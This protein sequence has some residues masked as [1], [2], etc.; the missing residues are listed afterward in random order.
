M[1]DALLVSPVTRALGLALVHFLWQGVAIGAIVAC[2]LR[3]AG[4][5]DPST[6]YAV[7]CAGLVAMLAAPA[8]T[9]LWLLAVATPAAA[10]GS[11]AGAVTWAVTIDV[12]A[13][14]S[15][16]DRVLPTIVLVW[17]AGVL[18]LALHLASGWLDVR[19]LRRSGTP[20]VRGWQD[21]ATALAGRLGIR[22]TVTVLESS[23]VGVPT[24][25]GW[26]RP[27][28]LLPTSV[29][30]G[31][32]PSQLDAIVT[33]EL[34]HVRRHDYLVN[35]FQSAIETLLFYHPAVWWV[36]N[37][38]RLEREHCCDDEAVR[39]CGDR[40]SYARALA[41]LEER[42][43]QA[44]KLGMAATG[45]QL[46]GR[47]RR[48][49]GVTP[50]GESRSPGLSALAVTMTLVPLL[51]VAG[52]AG[53]V[54]PAPEGSATR[55]ASPALAVE[56][57]GQPIRVGGAMTSPVKIRDV[58]PFY[59]ETAREA[60]VQGIVIVEAVISTS[61]EVEDARVLRGNPMLDSAALDA[62]RQWRYTPSL[63]NGQPVSVIMTVT[64]NFTLS[65]SG[66]NRTVPPASAGAVPSPPPPP[67]PGSEVTLQ[68]SSFPD[69]IVRAGGGIP[70]PQRIFDAAP[71]Y[72]E[73]ARAAGVQGI[74]IAEV[75]IDTDG[76]VMDIR[77]LRSHPLLE[78]AAVDAIWQWRYEPVLVDGQAVP[79]VLTVTLNFT[80]ENE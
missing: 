33:H 68:T 56:Q 60:R 46:L 57:T 66:T 16:L 3:R 62:V 78:N 1:M 80:L 6:R 71:V 29:L 74:V 18:A 49:L 77:V 63:L 37:Q 26:I 7:T 52:M 28:I 31:L 41:S 76:N 4:D 48:L 20:L 36:S 53:A 9:V 69:D 45:G 23:R 17:A 40:I 14:A 50:M 43:G 75:L 72:P 34:A 21:R 10:A 30:A 13:G 8:A 12:G 39:A 65:G 59:P 25:L 61:G 58:R 5:A 22:G 35:V 64:L 73:A 24:V 2:I 32:S 55:A 70:A 67:S 38:V 15:A 47:V 19:R 42:R 54:E 44:V 51:L 27:A 79:M 11:A